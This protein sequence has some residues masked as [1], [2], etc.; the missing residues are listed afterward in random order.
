MDI[1]SLYD[2]LH[3]DPAGYPLFERVWKVL[4]LAPSSKHAME[5]ELVSMAADAF[6]YLQADGQWQTASTTGVTKLAFDGQE[7]RVLETDGR[8]FE[9]HRTFRIH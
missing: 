2:R 6:D 3:R 7:L 5:E 8:K 1:R 9:Y 4:S